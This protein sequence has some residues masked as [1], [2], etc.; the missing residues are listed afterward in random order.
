MEDKDRI[1]DSEIRNFEKIKTNFSDTDQQIENWYQTMINLKYE[2][3]LIENDIDNRSKIK[4]VHEKIKEMYFKLQDFMDCLQN[5]NLVL[6]FQSEIER[7]KI[8]ND[9]LKIFADDSKR[10][11]EE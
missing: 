10:K 9:G 7:L 11:I 8:E 3:S 6:N 1:L 5:N 4:L 2:L